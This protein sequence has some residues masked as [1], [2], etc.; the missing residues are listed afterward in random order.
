LRRARSGSPAIS[1]R[2][3]PAAGGEA[4]SHAMNASA[5]SARYCA[6]P[7]ALGSI[8]IESIPF[9]TR[10]FPWSGICCV[11]PPVS[12]PPSSSHAS[13]RPEPL[14]SPNGMIAPKGGITL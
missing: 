8:R 11:P 6:V 13:A 14:C 7:S 10:I 12:A 2:S 3:T 9:I 1:T 4:F 5:C